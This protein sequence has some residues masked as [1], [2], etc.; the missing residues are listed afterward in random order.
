MNYLS[1]PEIRWR[2]L[3]D[4]RFVVTSAIILLVLVFGLGSGWAQDDRLTA[5]V[6]YA[7]NGHTLE[8]LFELSP[9]IPVT[10]IR[11]EGIEAPDLA[12]EPWGQAARECLSGLSNQ[13]IWLETDDWTPDHYGR[14]WAY[15]WD[16]KSLLNRKVLE[17]GGA[18]LNKDR[19][20]QGQYTQ[21]LIYAQEFARL[22]G[23]GIWNPDNPLRETPETFRRRSHS[24]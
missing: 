20:A 23:L 8:L 22:L 9:E 6:D 12:Q 19:I 21:Q 16:G 14:L 18:Y 5:T 4:Y 2:S 3:L 17:Q 11:L 7:K 10:T 24:P 1:I 15:G 13:I